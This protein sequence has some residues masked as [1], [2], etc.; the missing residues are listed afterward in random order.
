MKSGNKKFKLKV[1]NT[2]L[3]LFSILIFIAVLTWIIPGGEYQRTDINGREV[4]VQ[5]SFRY[6]ESDPQ[7]FIALFTAPIKGFVE[8]AMIIGF[9]LLVGGAFNV[10][11]KTDAINSLINKLAR[12]HKKSSTL[13][14]MFV[15]VLLLMFSIG[16][17]TFGMNEEI[18]PFVLIIVP[19][20]LALGY[21]SIV[22][23]AIP[24]VGAHV[25]FA[26]AYLN[27][28]NVGIA[29]GIADVPIFSGIGY[30]II[31]W[32]ISTTLAIDRKS[33]V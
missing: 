19:I 25:G 33:V 2:Y 26:S 7:G 12:A 3:L 13:R 8:A 28:F 18:I 4:V 14:K 30:R 5:N 23:V 9:I 24:L 20:C 27:P 1:P 22:G 31:C 15:P 11:A 10:L 16:G 17:A 29:Q 6:I 32:I 21:D